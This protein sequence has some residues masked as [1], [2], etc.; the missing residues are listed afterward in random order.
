MLDGSLTIR[1]KLRH[2]GKIEHSNKANHGKTKQNKTKNQERLLLN[3]YNGHKWA[4]SLHFSFAIRW[5]LQ[6]NRNA[7][8]I[9]KFYTWD[10]KYSKVFI[11]VRNAKHEWNIAN[12]WM[13]KL[14]LKMQYLNYFHSISF[15]SLQRLSFWDF[16]HLLFNFSISFLFLVHVSIT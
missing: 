4:L 10:L 15:S 16:K 1:K 12:K 6:S 9:T 13:I 11:F 7:G 14:I 3:V 5:I 2:D 8:F